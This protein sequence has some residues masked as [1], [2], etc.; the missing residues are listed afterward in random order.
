MGC[1]RRPLRSILAYE[2]HRLPRS[3]SITAPQASYF[4]IVE[5]RDCDERDGDGS[6]A[7]VDCI[8]TKGSGSIKRAQKDV[9]V[10]EVDAT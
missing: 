2:Y 9:S 1:K 10:G 4:H 6:A 8:E 7:G 3:Q 5:L